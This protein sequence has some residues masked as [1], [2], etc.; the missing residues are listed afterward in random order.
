MVT[1]IL[2]GITWALE[3]VI[4]G[5]ALTMTPFV[6]DEMGLLLAPFVS[7]FIHDGISA[8]YMLIYNGIK[9]NIKDVAKILKSKKSLWLISASAI[10]GPVGMTGYVLAVNYMGASVGAVA[11]AVYPAIGSVLAYFFLKEKIRWYQW[12]F[13]MLTLL[14]VF[15]LSYSPEVS[16]ENFW[17]G[18]CGVFMCAFGWGIEGVILSKCLKDAE[19]KSEYALQIRQTT[20]AVIY[21]LIILPLLKGWS[22]T[23]DLFVGEN[24]KAL[25]IIAAAALCATVSYLLYY[26]TIAKLGVSKAMGLNI[27]YT[28]WAMIFTVVILRD[29]SVLNVVTVGCALVVVICG[30]FAAADFRELFGRSGGVES[31]DNKPA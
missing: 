20:S 31:K 3:T 21:G 24:A 26:K 28:A 9:G 23:A 13:L 12:I 2:A 17:L 6:S 29:D 7:T 8:L 16:I 10:G 1:G 4:L 30:I 27:T 5:I 18:I 25:P 11:S 19:I 22:F 15:G 14:G